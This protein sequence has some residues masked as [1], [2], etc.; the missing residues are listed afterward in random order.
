MQRAHIICLIGLLLAISQ[1]ATAADPQQIG[2]PAV[3][4]PA[5]VEAKR[6]PANTTPPAPAPQQK[7]TAPATDKAG[8]DKKAA[9]KK[10]KEKKPKVLARTLFGKAETAAA[11]APRALGWYSKGCLSGGVHLADTGPDWQTMRLSRNRAWGH[12][13]LIKLLKRLASESK[14]DGWTGL[15]VGDISQPRGGPMLSGHASHQVGLDAD[16]WLTPM[17]GRV[18]SRKE[19]EEIQATTMLDKTSLAVD[20]KV[21]TPAHV[22]II[23]R[24]ASYPQVE[25]IFVNPAIKKA[26]CEAAGKDRAWLGK[27]RPIW[28]HNYHFHIRI[29]CP[30]GGCQVQPAVSG[31]DGCGKEVT[32]WLKT[33]EAS[34]KKPQPKPGVKIIPD[35]ERRQ[36]TMEQLPA[37]CKVVLNSPGSKRDLS[38]EVA[39]T[40]PGPTDAK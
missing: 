10:E 39:A 7:M 1:T 37:E 22:A 5:P 17:P 18:L 13:K 11:L 36:V 12:P 40:P 35:S 32:N 33:I 27:V 29:G 24:A 28:G 6:L 2:D 16:I 3:K 26:L 15:L 31:D 38:D 25:R 14:Q 8:A 4:V 9:G 20:P 21:F 34:L 23:K 19:R 30:N